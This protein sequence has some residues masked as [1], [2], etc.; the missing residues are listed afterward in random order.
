MQCSEN[1]IQ[2]RTKI[3]RFNFHPNVHEIRFIFD[4]LLLK[5]FFFIRLYKSNAFSIQFNW[6]ILSN[7]SCNCLKLFLLWKSIKSIR[8][9]SIRFHKKRFIFYFVQKLGTYIY[10]LFSATFRIRTT[11][12]HWTVWLVNRWLLSV[13]NRKQFFSGLST[14]SNPKRNPRTF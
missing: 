5:L 6:N 13:I 12:Y 3:A 10:L 8:K 9:K 4:F 2:F 1:L 11:W 7:S 14:K